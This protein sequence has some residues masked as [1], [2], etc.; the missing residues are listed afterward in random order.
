MA[1]YGKEN[2]RRRAKGCDVISLAGWRRG[3]S[4]KRRV[5]ET[6]GLSI[7]EKRALLLKV[8]MSDETKDDD[9]DAMIAGLRN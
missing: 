8:I 2:K 9:L 1:G 6:Q 7:N 3:R 5:M 4:R